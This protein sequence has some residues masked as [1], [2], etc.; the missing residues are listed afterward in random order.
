MTASNHKEKK[1]KQIPIGLMKRN[2]L[3][4][5]GV[6][7]AGQKTKHEQSKVWVVVS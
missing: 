5:D 6:G 2:L 4:A 7:L 3:E 1:K